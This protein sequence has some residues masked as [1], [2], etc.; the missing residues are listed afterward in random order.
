M[1]ESII[2]KEQIEHLANLARLNIEEDKVSAYAAQIGKILEFVN[3]LRK[4]DADGVGDNTAFLPH[5]NRFRED[6]A[7]K[8]QN[9]DDTFKNAP[10]R[11]DNFI[12]MPR[13]L[14]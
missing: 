14:E 2:N 4:I 11:K 3:T 8:S 13:I 1:N 12:K 6:I 9:T 10:D 5:V 7:G